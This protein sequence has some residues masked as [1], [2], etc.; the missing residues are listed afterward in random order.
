MI[1]PLRSMSLG[2]SLR[3]STTMA[4]TL[5]SIMVCQSSR[6]ASCA[7]ESPCASPALFTSRSISA[8]S[9]GSAASAASSAAVSRTSKQA[10]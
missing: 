9:V 4:V 5:V 10:A 6:L 7:G 3:V 2:N 8:N 1:A